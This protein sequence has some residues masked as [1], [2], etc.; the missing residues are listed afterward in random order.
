MTLGM[1]IAV[2]GLVVLLGIILQLFLVIFPMN[3][4]GVEESEATKV[5]LGSLILASIAAIPIGLII[6]V[7][8]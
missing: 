3:S 5:I 4:R 2:T 6:H 8:S 7:W 1:K